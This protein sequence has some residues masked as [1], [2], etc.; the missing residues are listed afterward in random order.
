MKQVDLW[1]A[2]RATGITALVLLTATTVLGILVA[3]RA[4]APGPGFA[5]AEVHRR[6]SVL[7]VVFLA[8]HVLTA[9]LDSYVNIGWPAIVVPFAS[10]Y[11]RLGVAL[12]TVAADLLIAVAMSSAVRRWIPARAWRRLHWLAYLSW[13][14]AV[15][16][17]LATGTDSRFSWALVLVAACSAAV[18]GAAGW[19]AAAAV[20]ARGAQPLTII[21]PRRSLRVRPAP[22]HG[23][24]S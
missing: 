1:Y 15:S 22:N 21:S 7:A 24:G 14:V 13:P 3:G 8:V 20:R 11:R 16:H 17:T 2:T 19:R 23:G 10:S 18:V 6:V 12:G 4:R 9:V 5:R